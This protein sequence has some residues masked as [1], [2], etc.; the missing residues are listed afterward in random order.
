PSVSQAD[1]QPLL[2]DLAVKTEG[3]KR[4]A[5]LYLNTDWG[6]TSKD[7]FAAAVKQRGAQVVAAEGYQPDEKDFRSTLVRVRDAKP[8]GIVL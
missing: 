4:V 2:A 7:V 1:A 5:V 3:F 6:R 8:D